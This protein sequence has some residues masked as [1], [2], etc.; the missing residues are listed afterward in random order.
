MMP[1][2]L[3]Q[4]WWLTKRAALAGAEFAH[5]PNR[6]RLLGSAR[7]GPAAIP[8]AG[9][10][11]FRQPQR[12]STLALALALAC[13]CN[14]MSFTSETVTD[15]ATTA[16]LGVAC[17]AMPCHGPMELLL[18]HLCQ[19]RPSFGMRDA[20]AH[21]SAVEYGSQSDLLAIISAFAQHNSQSTIVADARR[22]LWSLSA[23]SL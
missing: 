22:L 20:F 1:P 3:W 16:R 8:V 9:G 4:R 5:P 14:V 6:R 10:H 18:R 7:A 23:A 2:L 12:C 13:Q 19:G 11:T 21:S 17:H 15:A